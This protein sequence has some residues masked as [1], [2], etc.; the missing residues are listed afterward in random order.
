MPALLI[1]T[2]IVVYAHDRSEPDKQRRAREIIVRLVWA[3]AALNQVGVVLTEDLPSAEVLAAVRFAN[4]LEPRYDLAR[5][6]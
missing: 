1:D 3:M 4:P 2:N 5:L 6:D